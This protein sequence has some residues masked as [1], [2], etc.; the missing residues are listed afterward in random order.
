M[1]P[2]ASTDDHGDGSNI[3]NMF[4]IDVSNKDS[5][6]S[7]EKLIAKRKER[8]LRRKIQNELKKQ[9]YYFV[10]DQVPQP[11]DPISNYACAA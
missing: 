9:N 11:R 10:R 3:L 8:R 2:S 6:Y 1:V 5:C 4:N 7:A